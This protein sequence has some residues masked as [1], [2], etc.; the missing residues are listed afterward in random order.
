MKEQTPV[1]EKSAGKQRGKPFKKGKSGNP[2]GKPT[3][4][5]NRITRAAQ[6][7]LDGEAEAITR[8]AMDMALAGDTVALRLCLER[9]VPPRKERP[10]NVSL[11]SLTTSADLAAVTAAL[12]EAAA[13][14]VIT[15]GEAQ[16]MGILAEGHRKTLETIELE[17]RITALEAK[18][19]KK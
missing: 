9:I 15:P 13:K 17:R 3:G 11:P 5:L 6:D 12:L 10:V 18:E 2:K 19:Q 16:A 4:C 1:A 7:L 8:K 14:G